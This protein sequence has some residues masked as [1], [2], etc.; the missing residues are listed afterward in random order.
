VRGV[1]SGGSRLEVVST[2]FGDINSRKYLPTV[3]AF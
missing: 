2:F 3:F 1:R